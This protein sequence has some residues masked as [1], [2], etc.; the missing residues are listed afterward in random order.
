M[1]T[2]NNRVIIIPGTDIDVPQYELTEDQAATIDAFMTIMFRV[3]HYTPAPNEKVT[4]RAYTF[5]LSPDGYAG[6]RNLV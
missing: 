2:P 5:L 1:T 4:L 3:F 6:M